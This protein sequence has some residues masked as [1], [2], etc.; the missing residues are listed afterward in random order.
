MTITI[1][2]E[3]QFDAGHRLMNH[4]G[5]CANVHGHRYRAILHCEGQLD[6]V[7]RV[8]DFSNLKQS[9]GGWIQQHWDHAF[10]YQ[11]GDQLGQAIADAHRDYTT[12][13]KQKTFELPFPPTAE[14]MACWLL[15]VAMLLL[16]DV[17]G[18]VPTT[19]ELYETPTSRA[20]AD[21]AA[22]DRVFPFPVTSPQFPESLAR[23]LY[24]NPNPEVK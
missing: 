1:S 12:L 2:K 9:W 17:P 18:L 4:E 14:Y 8:V 21:R 13:R 15:K 6:H 16:R 11:T 22:V 23:L 19:V 24:T 3:V 20:I 10:V 5:Q 7:G